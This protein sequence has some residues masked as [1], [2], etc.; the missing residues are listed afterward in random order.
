[1]RIG[2]IAA[3]AALGGC[4]PTVFYTRPVPLDVQADQFNT[5]AAQAERLM[6]V[7]NVM[8]ARDR[9]SMVFTRLLGFTGSMQRSLSAGASATAH[10]G[11]DGGVIS[12]GFTVGGQASPSFNLA[13]L[14]DQKFHR[15]IETSIDLGLYQSLIDAGWRPNLLHTLF[16][17]RVEFQGQSYNNDPS[18]EADFNAFQTWLHSQSAP[19][20]ICSESNPQPFSPPLASP[21]AADLQ[22]AAAIA[23]QQLELQQQANGAYQVVRPRSNRWFGFSCDPAAARPRVTVRSI[24]GVLFYLGEVVRAEQRRNNSPPLMVKIRSGDEPEALFVVH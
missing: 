15:A 16:I 8:R 18:S 13:I 20:Q 24:E 21:N 9:T 17:E 19:L 3:A 12:P 22:G 1:M 10:E 7:R 11:G 6:I 2:L 5:T 4:V 14:N 23:A